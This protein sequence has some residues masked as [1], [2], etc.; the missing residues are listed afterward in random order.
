MCATFTAPPA[1]PTAVEARTSVKPLPL[2][3]AHISCLPG[4][5]ASGTTVRFNTLLTGNFTQ[6]LSHVPG[7]VFVIEYDSETSK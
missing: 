1:K 4:E 3:G 2:L 6:K 7:S 5:G